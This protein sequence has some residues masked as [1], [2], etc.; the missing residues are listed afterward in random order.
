MKKLEEN[1]FWFVDTVSR[2]KPPNAKSKEALSSD[3]IK[4]GSHELIVKPQFREK[5]LQ[6]SSYLVSYRDLALSLF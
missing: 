4:I 1:H 6:V 2:F 5:A 3:K